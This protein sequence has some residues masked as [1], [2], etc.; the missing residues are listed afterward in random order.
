MSRRKSPLA[1]PVLSAFIIAAPVH[2]ANAEGYRYDQYSASTDCG[3]RKPL[4]EKEQMGLSRSGDIFRILTMTGTQAEKNE[5]AH[6]MVLAV[7]DTPLSKAMDFPP[8]RCASAAMLQMSDGKEYRGLLEYQDM[9][10]ESEHR[11]RAYRILFEP[12]SPIPELRYDYGGY[13]I[14]GHLS[15]PEHGN[16]PRPFAGWWIM[17]ER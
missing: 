7:D 2:A 15:Y 16:K 8:E 17:V 13:R 9:S 3:D 14:N 10:G 6:W 11:P 5:T 4:T 1:G 12:G